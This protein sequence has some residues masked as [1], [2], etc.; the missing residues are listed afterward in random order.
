MLKAVIVREAVI[1]LVQVLTE[2]KIKVTQ[3]GS[4]AYV[5]YNRDGSPSVVNVPYIPDDAS[6]EY[7]AAIQGFL[8]HEVAHVLFLIQR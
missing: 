3:R 4:K 7:L 8:D 2:R 1:K 5:R 6:E